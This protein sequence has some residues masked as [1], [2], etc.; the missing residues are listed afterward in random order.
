MLLWF[1]GTAVAAV[2]YVFHD[3]RFDYRLLVVGAVLPGVIDII[4]GLARFAHSLGVAV[5]LL[6]VVMLTTGRK[7]IRRLLLGL[8]IGM[9]LH[10]VFDGAFTATKVF[11]WPFSGGWGAVRTPELARGWWNVPM[12]FAGALL[13]AWI[14]RF[15]GLASADRRRQFLHTGHLVPVGEIPVA[16]SPRSGMGSR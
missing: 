2:W 16:A 10:L 14:W 4:G 9:M 13:V 15:F 1:V 7:P 6:V 3:V 8:P 12:E 5:G 11:W